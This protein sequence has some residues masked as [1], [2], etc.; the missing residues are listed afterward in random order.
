M[1]HLLLTSSSSQQIPKL[2]FDSECV[3]PLLKLAVVVK[4]HSHYISLYMAN[5]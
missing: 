3:S 1:A 4:N 2:I 5:K